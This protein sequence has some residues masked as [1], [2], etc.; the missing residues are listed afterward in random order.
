MTR[1][2]PFLALACLLATPAQAAQRHRSHHAQSLRTP[3]EVDSSKSVALRLSPHHHSRSKVASKW[4]PRPSVGGET[5]AQ[6]AARPARWCGWQMRLWFG[7]GPE[8]NLAR[9][10]AR[11]GR[12]SAPHVGAIIVW[13]HHVGFISG[14]A[15]DGS[16]II[17]SG[18]D[19]GRV[20]ER[21]RSIAG[22]IAVREK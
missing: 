16:W 3:L 14:Q 7:G 19:G 13:P 15:A 11:V 10:W 5:S 1:A 18:N 12:P 2:L 9:N 20:R 4:H 21:V 17:K 6:T 8:L 22:A